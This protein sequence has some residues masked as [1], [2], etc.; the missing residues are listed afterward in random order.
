MELFQQMYFP[1]M[2]DF[3]GRFHSFKSSKGS[4][5]ELQIPKVRLPSSIAEAFDC[6]FIE[7]M[8][9]FVCFDF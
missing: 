5:W 1:F 7:S 9:A 3:S 6:I 2:G 4:I 8:E